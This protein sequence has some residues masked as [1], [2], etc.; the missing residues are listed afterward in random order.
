MLLKCSFCVFL[1]TFFSEI[2]YSLDQGLRIVG[3]ENNSKNNRRVGEKVV[4]GFQADIS[5]FPYIAFLYIDLKD[6]GE[7][8]SA[9]LISGKWLITAA[10]CLFDENREPFPIKDLYISVGSQYNIEKN[11]NVYRATKAIAHPDYDFNSALNDI[12]IIL[13]ETA[14]DP[15]SPQLKN[16]VSFAKIYN[17]NVTDGLPVKAAGWGVTSNDPNASISPVLMSVPLLISSDKTC[18]NLNPAWS[19]ND[20]TSICTLNQN[21]QDTCYGDSGGPLAYIGSD[22]RPLVGITSI[23]NAPGNPDRPP[24]GSVGGSAYYTNVLMFEDISTDSAPLFPTPITVFTGFLGSGKT[25][26]ILNIL[27]SLPKDYNLVLLKNEFGD[28]ETDSALAKESNLMVTEMTNGCLCCVLVGQMK[29]ALIEIKEKYN[30]DRIIVETSGS[31]FPAPIA[32]QIRQMKDLGFRLDSIMTVIDCKNFMGYE[33]T[34]Y[35]AK[36]QAKYTDLIL[37]NKVELVTEREL[38]IVIDAV[39]ELNTDT[40]KINVYSGC[41]PPL[42]LVFGVDTNLFQADSYDEKNDSKLGDHKHDKSHSKNEV[43]IIEVFKP[44]YSEDKGS[45]SDSSK[46]AVNNLENVESCETTFG[47]SLS[48][49][50]DFLLSLPA[51]DVYRVKGIILISASQQDVRKYIENFPEFIQTALERKSQNSDNSSSPDSP[52][53]KISIPEGNPQLIDL[54]SNATSNGDSISD[55][56]KEIDILCI[57]NFA[58]GRYV[59]T[60]VTSKSSLETLKSTKLKLVFMGSHLFQYQKP[61]STYFNL[62]TSQ[63]T[64]YFRK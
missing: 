16:K 62:D 11:P 50:N 48:K 17:K 43:D 40:A 6:T 29:N 10:H 32:W 9:S 39:N 47:Y 15:D 7:A 53:K 19:G 44:L 8:C 38:D 52:H 14:V 12:G 37:L 51:D 3:V 60:P 5:E 35:T 31:A 22:F 28:A 55:N 34:S 24:C 2:V 59:L 56:S 64:T 42:D 57:L 21:G 26:I 25:T 30:P 20:K 63:I 27:K 61:I 49:L 36:L 1:I 33:D 58:F 13:L 54:L 4:N 45:A 23:G 18:K 41:T 46:I